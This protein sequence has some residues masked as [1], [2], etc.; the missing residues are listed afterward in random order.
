MSDKL[1]PDSPQQGTA[2]QRQSAASR[3]DMAH[4]LDELIAGQSAAVAP[5]RSN[6]E[7]EEQ[8]NSSPGRCP[9]RAAWSLLLSGEAQPIEADELLTTRPTARPAPGSFAVS[10]PTPRPG[11]SPQSP[12]FLLP[13]APGRNNWQCVSLKLHTGLQGK[14]RRSAR[15]SIS[16]VALPWLQLFCWPLAASS[17]GAR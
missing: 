4:A 9:Q 16:G 11:K 6:G 15:R 2:Q 8:L 7:V 12:R 3:F 1:N 5:G 14:G 17:A 10:P 13:Q